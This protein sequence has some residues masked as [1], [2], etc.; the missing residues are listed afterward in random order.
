MLAHLSRRRRLAGG[1]A[2]S[3]EA[4][5][6]LVA[7][8]ALRAQTPE[9]R[10]ESGFVP[11]VLVHGYGG[12][13]ESMSVL[14]QRLRTAGRE[15]VSVDLPDNGE[16][17]ILVSARALSKA[18]ERTGAR[19]FDF[20]GFSAGGVVVRAYLEDL[21]GARF[22]RHVVLLA[23]P[24]HGTEVAAVAAS[25]A[26]EL[27][28]G[29]CADLVP[30]SSF[31]DRLNA[32][33]ET[34][35]GPDYTTVWTSRDETVT[36]PSSATLQGAVNVRLQDVC[37]GSS[38]GHGELVTDPTALALVLKALDGRLHSVPDAARCRSPRF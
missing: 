32:G 9:L 34:A 14:A 28:T 7:L 10:R 23:A 8:L 30:G 1:I 15:V 19:K 36:P 33:D 21:N 17:H 11:V 29:A 12:T 22:A 35:V 4:I 27:C 13:S 31:L 38:A 2:A 25:T 18:V 20:V 3:L 24:N 37:P 16:D 6:L 5:L 26:A